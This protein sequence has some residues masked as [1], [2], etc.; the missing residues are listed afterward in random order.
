MFSGESKTR[1]LVI[2]GIIAIFLIAAVWRLVD[3]QIVQGEEFRE[4]SERRF[5]RAMPVR[6]PRGEIMDR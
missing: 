5:I 6:A 2:L 1:N 3:L 4:Q